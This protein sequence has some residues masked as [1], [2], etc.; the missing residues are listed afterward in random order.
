MK[1]TVISAVLVGMATCTG[2]GLAAHA[3]EKAVMVDEAIQR[4][5][6]ELAGAAETGH[7]WRLIDSAGGSKSQDLDKLLAIAKEKQAAG[8][9]DEALRLAE[10]T[11]DAAALGQA[12][13]ESQADAAPFYSE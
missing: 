5:E 6:S 11:A 12:Q 7:V 8:E 2:L 10:R 1:N 13:A 4:A 9:L 3:E